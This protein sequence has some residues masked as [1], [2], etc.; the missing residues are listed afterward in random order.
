[1]IRMQKIRKKV[2][3]M[4]LNEITWDLIDPLIEQG[5]LP[6]FARL[7]REGTWAS[8][9]STDVPPLMDPWITWTT[10]YTGRPQSDHG[11]FFLQQ[12]PKT[13]GAPRIWEI[14]SERGLRVGVYGSLCSWPPQP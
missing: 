14:L 8:P 2:L 5:K 11:V 7:K 13:I 9:L 3:L 12:P 4:E 10:V 1:M 6:T